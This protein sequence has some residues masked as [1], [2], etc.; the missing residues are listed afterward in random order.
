M[1]K[2]PHVDCDRCER[3]LEKAE[4]E[5]IYTMLQERKKDPMFLS[6]KE[7]FADLNLSGGTVNHNHIKVLLEEGG[8]MEIQ[9]NDQLLSPLAKKALNNAVDISQFISDAIECYVRR[10][11]MSSETAGSKE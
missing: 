1:S 11:E 7:V 3:L 2:L 10:G 6:T 5:D 4:Q 9:F 8:V